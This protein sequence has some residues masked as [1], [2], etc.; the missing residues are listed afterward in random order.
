MLA[1]RLFQ[2]HHVLQSDWVIV[3]SAPPTMPGFSPRSL[4]LPTILNVQPTVAN[5]WPELPEAIKAGMLEMVKAFKPESKRSIGRSLQPASRRKYY[6]RGSLTAGLKHLRLD[7]ELSRAADRL[8]FLLR[9]SILLSSIR[10]TRA[11][12]PF[13]ASVDPIAARSLGKGD[14]M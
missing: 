1:S 9:P 13:D 2:V 5:A 7:L 14:E 12:R 3:L 6:V 4:V 11:R 10:P 8:G